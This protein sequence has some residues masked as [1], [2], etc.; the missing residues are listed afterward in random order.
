M[1]RAAA[2]TGAA[3]FFS[4]AI[5]LVAG[6]Y[7]E[8][9]RGL[10]LG[11]FTTAFSAGAALG[12]FG[13]ALLVSATSWP[14]A[15][16][17]GG[18]GLLALTVIAVVTIPKSVGGPTLRPANEESRRAVRDVLRSPALWAIGIA[19][20]GLEGATF[21]TGQFLLPFGLALR[22]WS[23]A[24]AG[25]IEAMFLLPSVAG[26]PLG[27]PLAE[28]SIFRRT[29]LV[30]GASLAGVSVL[31]LPWAGAGATI[32]IGIVFAFTYGFVYSVMYVLPH[33]L[34]GLSSPEIPLAIGLFNSVQL[35]G[36][37]LVALAFG[38]VVAAFGYTIAWVALG[39]I[40]IGTLAA[41]AVVPRTGRVP[42][43]ALRSAG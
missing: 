41:M 18:A 31:F 5:G 10:P 22:G 34:P 29:Q 23:P 43:P 8:G 1:L 13:S 28:R 26:G 19:F 7:P 11:S 42:S 12:V 3:L 20:I 6:L 39:L 40:V 27:G 14:V 36:G 35:A 30:I 33:Y 2:G 15:F 4:P 17:A 9:K 32:A 16:L 25:A 37:G 21:A 24:L 38:Q